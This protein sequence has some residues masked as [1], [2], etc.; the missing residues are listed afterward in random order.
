MEVGKF[1]VG[2]LDGPLESLQDGKNR[3]IL[4]QGEKKERKDQLR[5]ICTC[6][7]INLCSETPSSHFIS[8][9]RS[10]YT[11]ATVNATVIVLACNNTHL[12]NCINL[13]RAFV[14]QNQNFSHIIIHV[15]VYMYV[16]MYNCS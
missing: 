15:R 9:E 11:T 16:H 4:E 10:L 5:I 6:N 14:G 1:D 2:F 7:N 13:S 12:Q 8:L 3:E